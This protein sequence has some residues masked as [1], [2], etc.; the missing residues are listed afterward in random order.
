MNMQLKEGL[1]LLGVG[2]VGTAIVLIRDYRWKRRTPAQKEEYRAKIYANAMD[3]R[4]KRLQ[5]EEE[6][7][8]GAMYFFD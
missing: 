1:F 7:L 4:E 8:E 6:R 5:N 2:L 3:H